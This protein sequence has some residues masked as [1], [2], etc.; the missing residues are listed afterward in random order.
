[1]RRRSVLRIV[2]AATLAAGLALPAMTA[3]LPHAARPEEVG[4]SSAR[5]SRL[6]E[7]LQGEVARGA[8]PGAVVIIGRRGKIA[9]Q[10]AVGF[11]DREAN[12][13]MPEDAVFRIASMTK[14][15]VS[16]GIMMLAEE[17][18]L[19]LT[20]PVARHL[21][22]F[23]EMRVGVPRTDPTTGRVSLALEPAARP[24]TV[25]DLLR[26]TS[27]LTY[28]NGED[29]VAQAY[30]QANLR[31]RGITSAEFIRRLAAL[32]L[33]HQPGTHW[34][35]SY[36]TDV[37]GRIIEV[38]SGTDLH[39]FVVERI[40]R[41]LG[42]T[43]TGFWAP[44]EA[45][46]R[47]AYPQ[48]D[49]NTGRRPAVPDPLVRPSWFSGGGGMVS[50]ARDYARFAQF[51]LNK[52]ELDG[53]RLVSRKTIEL[54]TANHLPAGTRYGGD[55]GTRFAALAPTPEMGQGFGLGFAVRTEAGL[56]PLPG[57]VGDYYWGGAYGTY[58]W[59]DPREDMY[60]ILMMQAPAQRLP[61]R[62]QLRQFAY[63][64]IVD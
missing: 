61:F 13:P 63:Q 4:L 10:Q 39:S 38:V 9:Y 12:A 19:S 45:T 33:M 48:T 27:G 25:Q 21:P 14:P 36:S 5:L 59:V 1:M 60:V 44:Q 3:E 54:M 18:R 6:S 51:L 52:G 23:Q 26:H 35:Y 62:Y 20:D 11:R 57:S 43:D 2:A 17:G 7:W 28:G 15:I 47:A 50:T 41:P 24:I 46:S 29:P 40:A 64:A 8:V 53:V 37:L 42:M 22:E 31:E 56:N 32:P 58:F 49:R 16:L 30:R 55:I 34:E